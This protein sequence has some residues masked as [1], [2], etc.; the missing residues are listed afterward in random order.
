MAAAAAVPTDPSQVNIEFSLTDLV[1][2]TGAEAVVGTS[3]H[4]RNWELWLYNAGRHRKQGHTVCKT[5]AAR[6]GVA[7]RANRIYR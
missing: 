4:V 7:G 2:G 1:V 5:E 6:Q 3:R